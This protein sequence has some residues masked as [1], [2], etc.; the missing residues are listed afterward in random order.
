MCKLQRQSTL[1]SVDNISTV[2]DNPTATQSN[3]PIVLKR[4]P[5]KRCLVDSQDEQLWQQL[6]TFE[7][8]SNNN[9]KDKENMSSNLRRPVGDGTMC[10]LTK[11]R[12]LTGLRHSNRN[13]T[14]DSLQS[15]NTGNLFIVVNI[16]IVCLL[17]I[18]F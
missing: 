2:S 16:I 17:S 18:Y 10:R 5:T 9:E 1:Q 12:G 3:L 6:E 14:T 15:S 11:P 7:N 13:N 8:T 4:N